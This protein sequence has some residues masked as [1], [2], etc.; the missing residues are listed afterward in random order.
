[1]NYASLYKLPTDVR[2]RLS[3][4]K[5]E[6]PVFMQ[7]NDMVACAWHDTKCV[8]FLSTTETNYTVEKR[9]RQR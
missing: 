2:H 5:R 8:H 9:I 1:M 6:D 4:K 7:A 3:L